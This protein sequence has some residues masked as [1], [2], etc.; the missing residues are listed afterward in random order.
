[1]G[2]GDGAFNQEWEGTVESHLN[3]SA[4]AEKGWILALTKKAGSVSLRSLEGVA[5]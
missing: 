2:G 5:G 1:V 4:T 3:Q